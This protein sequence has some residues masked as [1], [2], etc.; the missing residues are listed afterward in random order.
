MH[1]DW[2]PKDAWDAYIAM[3]KSMGK[4][5]VAT[6]YAQKLLIKKLEGWRNEGQDV[7]EI[8][9]QSIERSWTG[10][11]PIKQEGQKKEAAWWSTDE[12]TLKKGRE[13]HMEP[14]RGESLYDFR[15]RIRVVI[16]HGGIEVMQQSRMFESQ[17][18][19]EQSIDRN[20]AKMG[21]REAMAAIKVRH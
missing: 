20:V 6:E 2:L 12:L 4:K 15:K 8:I 14:K 5:Y 10:L 9:N 13:L 16:E 19:E 3:R 17:S 11:F 1:P 18:L 7:E 21:I